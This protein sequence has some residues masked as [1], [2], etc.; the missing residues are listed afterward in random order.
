MALPDA[1]EEGVGASLATMLEAD[2]GGKVAE[3]PVLANG[4]EVDA[5]SLAV[6]LCDEARNAPQLVTPRPQEKRAGGV[7][8]VSPWKK[9]KLTVARMQGKFVPEAESP[10]KK[11][12]SLVN[13]RPRVLEGPPETLLAIWQGMKQTGALTQEFNRCVCFVV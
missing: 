6:P 3:V 2:G 5:D 4:D 1:S 13:C 9:P 10:Q 8:D 12:S 11:A 7:H